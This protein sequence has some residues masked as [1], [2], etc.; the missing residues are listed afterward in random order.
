[1]DVSENVVPGAA[2]SVY[3]TLQRLP[4]FDAHRQLRGGGLP[5]GYSC[6]VSGLLLPLLRATSQAIRVKTAAAAMAMMMW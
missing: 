2:L 3:R 5:T 6:A 1:M 4:L